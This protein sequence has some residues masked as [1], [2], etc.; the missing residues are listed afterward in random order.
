MF[1]IRLIWSFQHT[2]WASWSPVVSNKLWLSCTCDWRFVSHLH[3]NY[4]SLKILG[5]L[6]YTSV[7]SS[8]LDLPLH[9]L[10]YFERQTPHRSISL[11]I[12]WGLMSHIVLH[13]GLGGRS[14][15]E[16]RRAAQVLLL[17]LNIATAFAFVT[18]Q[19]SKFRLLLFKRC[20]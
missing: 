12:K 19:F 7:C 17:S 16:L 9:W 8:N 20:F 13:I 18:R 1:V 15:F 14:V 11:L 5:I 6:L 3:R 4:L 2:S 10:L